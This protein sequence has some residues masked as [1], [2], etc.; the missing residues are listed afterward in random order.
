MRSSVRRIVRLSWVICVLMVGCGGSGNKPTNTPA[1][2]GGAGGGAAGQQGV[3]SAPGAPQDQGP[4]VAGGPDQPAPEAG[5]APQN[6]EDKPAEK[7]RVPGMDLSDE[8]KAQRSGQH[9]QAAQAALRAGQPDKAISEA[10]KALEVDESHAPSMIALGHAYYLKQWDDKA[11]A[12]LLIAKKQKTGENDP[13]LWM[14][15]GL[16]YDRSPGDEREDEALAAYEKAAQLK[17]DYVQAHMN[18]GAIYL[19]RKRYA[20][21]VVAFEEVVDIQRQNPRAQTNLGSAYRGRSADFTQDAGQRDTFLKKSEAAFKTAMAQN[22]TYPP[23]YFNLG[24]LY[25][26]ADPFPGME[27]LTRFQMA[28]R[29]LNEYKRLM[30]PALKQGDPVDEYLAFAQKEYD[31]EVKRQEIKKKKAAKE[32]EK[33]KQKAAEP[34]KEQPK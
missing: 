31:K 25:L 10:Q 30:G 15:L 5:G 18:R 17:A 8:Q 23:A 32:A 13:H 2:A 27:T 21:A 12:I 28:Q 6:P 3:Q 11:E 19:E 22:T 33:A 20:D 1:S 9:H 7:I 29:Y 16:I 4:Q 26:D 34:A 24:L 14:I